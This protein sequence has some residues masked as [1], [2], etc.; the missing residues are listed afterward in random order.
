MTNTPI[1]DWI[2]D[3]NRHFT[4]GNAGKAN[5]HMQ[6]CSLISH[7]GNANQNYQEI[8]PYMYQNSQYK[9]DY[10]RVYSSAPQ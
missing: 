9:N 2:K 3:M 6:K 7:H 8:S 4:K 10:M 1:E 5:E